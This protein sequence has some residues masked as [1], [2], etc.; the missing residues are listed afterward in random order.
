MLLFL[1]RILKRFC[2]SIPG[3]F[4]TPRMVHGILFSSTWLSR[5]SPVQAGDIERVAD[6]SRSPQFVVIL[7]NLIG[8]SCPLL[9]IN[10]PVST[11]SSCRV[12][13]T[14]LSETVTTIVTSE[15]FTF[16]LHGNSSC[17]VTDHKASM[18]PS[19]A[20]PRTRSVRAGPDRRENRWMFPSQR[21]I[22]QLFCG[23]W[24]KDALQLRS[25]ITESSA[26]AIFI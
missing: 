5:L 25:T 2:A 16:T 23:S 4:P 8:N 24:A 18:V 19:E 17:P 11:S 15:P 1:L 10:F 9:K 21:P 22:S 14:K 12:R 13:R 3:T 20:T 7:I 26:M 6:D